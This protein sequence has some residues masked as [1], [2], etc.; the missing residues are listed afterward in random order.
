[1]ENKIRIPF[2]C[3]S[4]FLFTGISRRIVRRDVV[5]TL[6]V[7]VT[8]V[9]LL[10]SQIYVNCYKPPRD[11]AVGPPQNQQH[12]PHRPEQDVNLFFMTLV[13]N[14]IT[15]MTTTILIHDQIK[16]S[17]KCFLHSANLCRESRLR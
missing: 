6:W 2:N 17:A 4:E 10:V 13:M 9:L 8:K 12:V 1:M 5:S 7:L 15:K 16:I 11:E 3:A 14:K